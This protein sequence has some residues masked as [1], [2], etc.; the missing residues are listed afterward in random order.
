[1]ELWNAE[2]AYL[3]VWK[4]SVNELYDWLSKVAPWSGDVS[5]AR[6]SISGRSPVPFYVRWHCIPSD[7]VSGNVVVC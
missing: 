3:P 1:M 7:L 4:L 2:R 5:F 6:G